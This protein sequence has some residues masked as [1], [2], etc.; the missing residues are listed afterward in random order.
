MD[1]CL[2]GVAKQDVFGELVGI[3]QP[4]VAKLVQKKVLVAGMTYG[5]WLLIYADR[6]RTEAS[7]RSA[8][9]ARDRRDYAIARQAEAKAAIDERELYRQD[10]LI[11]DVETVRT[12]MSEWITL[13]KTEFNNAVDRLITAIE[14]ENGITVD[15]EQ[16]QPDIDAA[17]RA[18]GDYRFEPT[19]ADS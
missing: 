9:E 8:N 19:A 18:I 6:L 2:T 5:Q 17:L 12:A 15:R 13:G 14:S 7:G 10:K 1:V 4:A 3:S 11:L 16:L